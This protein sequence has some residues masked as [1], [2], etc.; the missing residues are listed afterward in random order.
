MPTD[1]DTIVLGCG[2]MGA[3]TLLSLARRGRRVLGLDRFNPPHNQGEHHG[4]V[5]MFRTTYYEHPSYV[6][7]LRRSLAAW[8]QLEHERAETLLELTGALYIGPPES[9]LIAGCLR[10]AQEHNL[11]HE[12][13]DAADL[14]R[15][16]PMFRTSDDAIGLL[17]RDAGFL[18][19]ERAVQAMLDQAAAQGATIR[20]NEQVTGWTARA[21]S[22]EV[23]C[24]QTFRAANLIIT[25]GAWSSP[26]LSQLDL[27]LTVTRQV[28]GW[29]SPQDPTPF[30]KDRFPCWGIDIGAGALFYGFPALPNKRAQS[31]LKLARHAPGPQGD[32]ESGLRDSRP[33]DAEDFLPLARQFLP[34]IATAPCRT[35]TCLYTNSPDSHFI[36]DRHPLHPNVS[37]GAGFSGH[38]FKLAPAVGEI[39]ANLTDPALSHPEPFFSL[40]R[41]QGSGSGG[42]R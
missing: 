24:S 11:A 21:N 38:G 22:V 3:A 32:P 14:A 40:A 13:L 8:R 23:A 33:T 31:E 34:T 41:L 17:E 5:R 37:F 12:R 6:P 42:A 39:L 25:A 7:W 18:Y 9:E 15:R 36:I 20:T 16:F 28:Q 27:N 1:L 35:C 2:T 29:L 30:T 10:S 4:H 26:L 19:C